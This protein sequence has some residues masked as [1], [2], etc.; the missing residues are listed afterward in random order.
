MAWFGSG[1][2]S[3]RFLEEHETARAERKQ[4]EK[5]GFTER[6]RLFRG[7]EDRAFKAWLSETEA[8]HEASG[9]GH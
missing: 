6:A 8:E 1:K 5:L 9:R 7:R 2:S 3:D 4:A